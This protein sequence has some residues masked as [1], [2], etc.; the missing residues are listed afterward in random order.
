[1]K[2]DLILKFVFKISLCATIGFGC[3]QKENKQDSG[4]D[5]VIAKY[6]DQELRRSEIE[7]NSI[8]ELTTSDSLQVIS[9]YT[10]KWL[11]E[12]I[13]IKE[14]KSQL[15]HLKEI[16]ELTEKFRNDLLL[17]KF[18]E[19]ILKEKLD[20]VIPEKEMEE[21]YRSNKSR[22][23][24]ESTIFRFVF[25]KLNKPVIDS[26]NL[27]FL[28]K[29]LNNANLQALNF[30]CQNHAEICFLNSQK[31]NKWDEIKQ[32]IPSKILIEKN[33]SAGSSMSF[34]DFSHE[35]KIKFF[36]VVRPNQDPPL[37]F[38][39]EQATQA[40]LHKRKIVLIEQFK[41]QLY[42]RELKNKRIQFSNK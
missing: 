31:W 3:S 42:D 26:R 22:Y 36:E 17:L 18:E 27:E 32:H 19:K 15:N 21:Y 2:D 24:L 33:I 4:Q 20:T 28:W 14:A 29:N 5:T 1:M 35:Y 34:A 10:D 7:D 8:T 16:D 37:S 9:N 25:L 39:K 23:K 11:K 38:F 40:I 13:L 12:Q 30:Y 41:A 6:G